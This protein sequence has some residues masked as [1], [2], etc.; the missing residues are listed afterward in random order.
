MIWI[1]K[2]LLS[3][4]LENSNEIKVVIKAKKLELKSLGYHGPQTVTSL[5]WTSKPLQVQRQISALRTCVV[6]KQATPVN[7]NG[8][9]QMIPVGI[10]MH[11]SIQ[12]AATATSRELAFLREN[13]L[14]QSIMNTF[15][16]P[17]ALF[18]AI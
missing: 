1:V 13:P 14:G 10:S 7:Q 4:Y 5:Q 6:Q 9:D 8:A 12:D 15:S 2:S 16:G 3:E 11:L 18:T 17:R